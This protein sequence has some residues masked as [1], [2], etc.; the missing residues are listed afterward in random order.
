MVLLPQILTPLDSGL[1]LTVL[2]NLVFY[3]YNV[4]WEEKVDPIPS[5][6][7]DESTIYNFTFTSKERNT[8]ERIK[9]I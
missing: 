5:Q 9:E 1:T 3:P 6:V 7:S 2:K 4:R 8:P